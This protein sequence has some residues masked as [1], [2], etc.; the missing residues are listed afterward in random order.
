M[1]ELHKYR[2]DLAWKCKKEK[3]ADTF[4]T[5]D[6]G[7]IVGIDETLRNYRFTIAIENIIEPYFF[8]ERLICALANQTIPI[9]LGATKINE[10][11]NPNG[12]IQI[13][14]KSDIE[15]ILKGCTKEEYEKRLPAI[16][17]NYEKVKQYTKPFDYIWENYLV[18]K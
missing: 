12:I 5:F 1:C 7:N 4:G 8:T 2:Y 11:F 10:F 3:L 14:E 16:L 13:S 18:K 15:E 9:Y 6:G 17:E